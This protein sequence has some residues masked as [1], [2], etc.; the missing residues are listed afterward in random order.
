[1]GLLVRDHFPLQQGLRQSPLGL[2]AGFRRVRDHFP[3]QQGLRLLGS[4]FALFVGD[5]VR[6]HF[7]LQ[8]GLR[9]K[10]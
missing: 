10:F 7:P 1:M 4:N 2:P 8:Q 5:I 6:D 9:L 3:L